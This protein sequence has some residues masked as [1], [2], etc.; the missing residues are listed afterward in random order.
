[1]TL[2][3]SHALF[4]LSLFAVCV[5]HLLAANVLCPVKQKEGLMQQSAAERLPDTM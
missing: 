2:V 1:M 3:F 4:F 5:L